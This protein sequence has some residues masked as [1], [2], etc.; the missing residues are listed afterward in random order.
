M[1]KILILALVLITGGCA[2][3]T[4]IISTD[5]DAYMVSI[6]KKGF[7]SGGEVLAEAY[8][9]ANEFCA[10]ENK[11]VKTINSKQRDMVPFTSNAYAELSFSCID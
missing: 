8:V 4:G 5:K 2:M 3:S 11:K 7:V 10:K 1:R 6:Y 9:Q